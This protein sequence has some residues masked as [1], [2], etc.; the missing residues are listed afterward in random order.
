MHDLR[1]YSVVSLTHC[2]CLILHGQVLFVVVGQPK[3]Q[4]PEAI[5]QLNPASLDRLV[6]RNATH[7]P[8]KPVAWLVL[9]YADWSD[10]CRQHDAMIANLS[11][12]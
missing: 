6:K 3:Y 2:V 7:D 8:H 4:G 9:F 1:G 5:T 10:H 11:L 12:T